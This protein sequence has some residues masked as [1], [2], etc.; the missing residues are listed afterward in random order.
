MS[1][2]LGSSMRTQPLTLSSIVAAGLLMIPLSAK[3]DEPGAPGN[4]GKT[5]AA[6]TVPTVP[7]AAPA[8]GQIVRVGGDLQAQIEQPTKDRYS[9]A[10]GMLIDTPLP[11]GYPAPTPP[12]AIDIKTYPLVRRAEVTGRLGPDLGSNLAFFPLFNH[13]KDRN[14][15]M[16]SPVEMNY[17]GTGK[18]APEGGDPQPGTWTMSFLYRFP[19]QGPVGPDAKRANIKVVDVPPVTVI[20]MGVRGQYGY[21]RMQRQ[22]R[23]LEQWLQDQKI[24]DAAGEPRVFYYNGP[25]RRNAD[26]WAEVQIP[27]RLVSAVATPPGADAA[28][29]NPATTAK[30]VAPTPP[31][32]PSQK[33]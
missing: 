29:A 6:E 14:I 2:L 30:P 19:E 5:Q 31:D 10:P 20:A 18:E 33:P 15:E 24:W 13:I 26:K 8:E 27:I 12:G 21:A 17:T 25:D 16:T 9:F 3:A 28:A 22:W 23:I 32:Q 4:A 7:T 11:V 1:T